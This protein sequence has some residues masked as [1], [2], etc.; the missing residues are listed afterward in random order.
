MAQPLGRFGVRLA[1]GVPVNGVLVNDLAGFHVAQCGVLIEQHSPVGGIGDSVVVGL[2]PLGGHQIVQ[3]D[4]GL[5]PG[6]GPL[7]KDGEPLFGVGLG[8]LGFGLR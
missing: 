7:L 8:C 2:G 4:A 3:R 1:F 6:F 5:I